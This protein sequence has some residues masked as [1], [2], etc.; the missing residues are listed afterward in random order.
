M[1]FGGFVT[2]FKKLL[3]VGRGFK[4]FLGI[5]KGF[6]KDYEGFSEVFYGFFTA[7]H[8]LGYMVIVRFSANK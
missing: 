8:Q 2:T 6:L 1:V 5:L 3:G 4:K 7:C